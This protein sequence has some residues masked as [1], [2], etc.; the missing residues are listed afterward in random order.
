MNESIC[1]ICGNKAEEYP[2]PKDQTVIV[3]SYCGRYSVTGSFFIENYSKDK[4]N[5]YKVSSWIREQNDLFQTYPIFDHEKFEQIINIKDKKIKEKFDFLLALFANA[6][7]YISLYEDGFCEIDGQ[8]IADKNALW[9]TN[10]FLVKT[11]SKSYQELCALFQKA[12]DNKL[13][14]GE[15]IN[16]RAINYRGLTFDGFE[17]L[18]DLGNP[19][20][21]SKNIFVAFNF[22]D[23]LKK[24]FNETL[25][26]AIE[27]E[28]FNYVVVNQ[29]N[30]EHNK[31][32]ND[33][34]IGKL[35]SSR[36]VIADFTNH[37]NSVYF[38]A[39]FAMGMRIPIIWTVHEGHDNDMSFDTRQYPHIVWKN[40]ED[41]KKQIMDRIKVIC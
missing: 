40:G 9:S 22:E 1:K 15:I 24:V 14:D 32:I 3:C 39:G 21:N 36:I 6:P 17:Y 41:L 7:Q 2:S 29:D 31:N 16:F 4:T 13:V 12:I 34:I 26:Q 5:F 38:E 8:Y 25:K 11:W 20:Q 10:T 28:G 37:R 19:N 35:K 33:E 23:N 27:K 30:V 18:E